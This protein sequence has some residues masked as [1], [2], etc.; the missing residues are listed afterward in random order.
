MPSR[1]APRTADGGEVRVG[2]A[3]DRADLDARAAGHADR[4]RAVVAA[5]RRVRRRP[6]RARGRRADAD[7]LVRVHRRRADREHAVAWSTTPPMN[8]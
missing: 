2:R 6:G 3:V 4:L 1:P 5:V 8:W 7:P